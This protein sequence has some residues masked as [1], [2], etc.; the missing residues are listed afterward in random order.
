MPDLARR[1][2]AESV[3]RHGWPAGLERAVRAFQRPEDVR[4]VQYGLWLRHTAWKSLFDPSHRGAA[5]VAESG[6]GSLAISL[7]HDFVLVHAYC[8]NPDTARIAR[9]RAQWL[10]VRNIIFEESS[11]APG[12]VDAAALYGAPGSD[13]I[14]AVHA[15]LAPHGR[16]YIALPGRKGNLDAL[17]TT[18]RLR[19]LFPHVSAYR[20]ETTGELEETYELAS[21]ANPVSIRSM[22][23]APAFSLL[24]S[25]D[26]TSES[27]VDSVLAR[28]QRRLAEGAALEPERLVFASPNGLTVI[29]RE[30]GTPR[31]FVIRIPLDPLSVQRNETNCRALL[32]AGK[33]ESPLRNATPH[34]VLSGSAA[35]HP[36]F[37]ET[38]VSG[39]AASIF[40]AH[41]E[42][43]AAASGAA[44]DWIT[45]LH[46]RTAKRCLPGGEP[47]KRLVLA[48]LARAFEAF[49]FPEWKPGFDRLG[50]LL[51]ETLR[52]SGLPLVHCHGDYS[53]D[54]V[55]LAGNPPRVTG[56]IDWDL[57]AQNG[58][59]L[60]DFFY[61]LATQTRMAQH[62]TIG[63]V[64][65]QTIFPLRFDTAAREALERYCRAL[66]IPRRLL[67]P[68][69]VVAWLHHAGLRLE[70]PERYRFT[71]DGI[72]SGADAFPAA[73]EL[74]ESVATGIGIR[75]ATA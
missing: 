5:W 42:T 56:V 16:L 28:A 69:A 50:L 41:R 4:R 61:F 39:Q 17:R 65:R 15:R 30:A 51:T 27:L 1:Q 34:H 64:F 36:Y 43:K 19:K 3:A 12:P 57:A 73:L 7:A 32:A 23:R 55:L 6:Y 52:G 58:L 47:I 21:G 37:V 29:A 70:N 18:C 72:E 13:L 66:G 35:G 53:V 25:K 22:L 63:R 14:R 38:A 71:A 24:A 40:L 10:G 67:A 20:C 74:L 62:A 45:A 54:N 60:L 46:T 44:L 31:R 48:P 9:A 33:L 59:P 11:D 26:D 2:V 75:S 68:L 49:R 8:D